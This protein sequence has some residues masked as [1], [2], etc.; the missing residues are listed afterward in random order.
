M[1]ILLPS[2]TVPGFARPLEGEEIEYHAPVPGVER[3]LVVRSEDETRSITWETAAVPEDLAAA[4]T[5]TFVMLAGIDANDDRRRFELSIDDRPVLRFENPA[6][7]V[8]ES[9]IWEG[10]E[11]VS[12]EFRV[13]LVDRY[14]DAMGFLFLHVPRA[15][16]V[17]GA[18]LRLGVRGESAGTRTW[19]LVFDHEVR[20]GIDIHPVPAVV[21]SAEGPRQEIR[22]DL[23][24]LDGGGPVGLQSDAGTRQVE[25]RFGSTRTY[26][27]VPAVEHRSEIPV[28]FEVGGDRYEAQIRVE[29]VQ[30]L[31][32]HLIHHTHLDIGYTHLQDEV[33]RLQWN[34]LEEALRLGEES[35]SLPPEARF[36]WHPEA[37]WAV[38][39]YLEH[40]TE[41]ENDR[42]IEGIRRGWIHL[43]ALHT[44]LLTGIA[45]AEG[46]IRELEPS[47]KLAERTGV[48]IRSAMFT[49]IPGFAWGLATVLARAGVRYL[50]VGPNR[51]HRIGRFLETWADRP[52]W[53][54]APN[55]EHRVLV[56]VHGEGYS[57]FH[58]GLGYEHL[59]TRLDADRVL[60]SVESLRARGWKHPVTALRYN[61]GSDNGPPDPTLSET[62]RAWN[63]RY[64]SPRL[65]ISSSEAALAELE[66]CAGPE[67]EVVRADLNGIWEDGVA[68]TAR[69]TQS[70]RRAAEWLTAA[71]TLAA[72]CGTRLDPGRVY[73]A[74]RS[75]LLSYEHTWGAWNSISEPDAEL[76]RGQW[77]RKQAFVRE[78][79]ERTNALV[80][81]SLGDRIDAETPAAARPGWIEVV[82]PLGWTRSEVVI[83]DRSTSADFSGVSTESGAPLPCQRLRDGSIAFR[84]PSVPGFGSVRLQRTG[85]SGT[86]S[87]SPTMVADA[88]SRI[89][90]D[91]GILQVGLAPLSGRIESLRRIDGLGPRRNLVPEGEALAEWIYVR[92]RDPERAQRA[93]SGSVEVTDAGP[94]VWR[95]VVR[96][97]APGTRQGVTL[98]VRLVAG[99]D[100]LELEY[101]FDKQWTLD[102]ES[103][104]IAFPLALSSAT[105]DR[106]VGGALA[107]FRADGDQAPGANRN[108]YTIERWADIHD[109]SGGLN[110]FSIDAPLVQFGSPG[111]DPIVTG[112]RERVDPS[113]VLYSYLMNNYW[114]TNYRAAQEGPHAIRYV[115]R[116]HGGFDL[117][118]AESAGLESAHPLL[119]Y[120][121]KP[122]L[123]PI[124]PPVRVE[125]RW[126][127]AT[128]LRLTSNSLEVRIYNPSSENDMV[129]AIASGNGAMAARDF[130]P[131]EYGILRPGQVPG[132]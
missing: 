51:W 21:R 5:V 119:T 14:A 15:L 116:P 118:R 98:I 102:P 35:A 108:W 91:N 28:A 81:A 58:T 99:S 17:P 45:T 106:A 9:R 109:A 39:T 53:W 122:D 19:F 101:R 84:S 13:T 41:S 100:R 112:W 65:S 52:F 68:S 124:V 36:I 79:V 27:E 18:P 40:H 57:L 54:E 24:R 50:S 67:L 11:G 38:E 1:R 3:C 92:G 87:A 63:E 107:P 76:V 6:E 125:A 44:N 25:T 56:W 111:S 78:A 77:D 113:P 115:L 48:P 80:A 49:D 47:S 43:D 126:S 29:P 120:R 82:N 26:L 123:P 117:P 12:G 22:V 62:V 129:T 132:E 114:E 74:W 97:E 75:V 42:L 30:P 4:E 7:A 69:E 72:M 34:H 37:V 90:L 60:S 55:G 95:A 66:A 94:I 130:G 32:I 105:L 59:E 93:S 88:G 64:E 23:L 8:E 16:V 10:C 70:I 33:E 96:R 2:T 86:D 83:L 110:L 127:L 71:E 20:P 85:D 131:G 46:L 128:L 31:T 61:I 104:L 73:A 103:V 89:V 121:V